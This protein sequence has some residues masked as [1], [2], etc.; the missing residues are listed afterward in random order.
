MFWRFKSYTDLRGEGITAKDWRVYLSLQSPTHP[1]I[2]NLVDNYPPPDLPDGISD[3][4]L[5]AAEETYGSIYW[6]DQETPEWTTS[7][8][9]Y[10]WKVNHSY[11]QAIEDNTIFIC[12]LPLQSRWKAGWEMKLILHPGEIKP[13]DRKGQLCYLFTAGDCEVIDSGNGTPNITHYFKQ[14]DCKNLLKNTT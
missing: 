3:E 9:E 12:F 7:I 6:K 1:E 13:A 14:W 11:L 2:L 5:E 10:E 4:A 8:M